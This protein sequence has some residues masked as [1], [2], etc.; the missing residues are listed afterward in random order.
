MKLSKIKNKVFL[1]KPEQVS[2]EK[3]EDSVISS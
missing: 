2:T 1:N 3:K